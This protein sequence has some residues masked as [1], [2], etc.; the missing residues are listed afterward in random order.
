MTL[1]EVQR[2]QHPFTGIEIGEADIQR[3][4]E[5][6]AE[7]R[8]DRSAGNRPGRRPLRAYRDQL[9]YP[10]GPR[11]GAV[12]P[13][14]AGG[15]DP[16]AAHRSLEAHHRRRYLPTLHRRGHLPQRGL[17]G[18]LPPS[19]GRHHPS[20]PGEPPAAS[21]RP[22]RSATLP[23]ISASPWRCTLPA[24][25]SPSWRTST[26]P[27]PRRTSGAGEP[28]GRCPLVGRPGGGASRNPIVQNG[29]IR[30]P[31]TPGLGVTLNEAVVREHLTDGRCFEPTP[32]WDEERS[33]GQ[34]LELME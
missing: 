2:T 10:A 22:K 19:C 29:F 1:Q 20:R 15:P 31:D 11:A 17:S 3:I 33:A 34:A 5:Y 9:L 26:A 32:E 12:P 25:P 4:V 7:V 23:R 28:F 8:A 14:L 6:V 18:T 21:W 27:R 13:R 30:V 24:R 16:L